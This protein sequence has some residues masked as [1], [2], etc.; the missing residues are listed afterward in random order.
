M[1][2]ESAQLPAITNLNGQIHLTP[3]GLDLEPT[4]FTI[5]SGQA[6]LEA[7]SISPL[8]AEFTFQADSLQLSQIVP[9]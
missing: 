7:P 8:R 5:G 3:D 2:F 9:S 4:R 6:S 1:R